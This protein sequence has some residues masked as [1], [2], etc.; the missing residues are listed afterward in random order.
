MTTT[1][2]PKSERIGQIIVDSS[3]PAVVRRA[4]NDLQRYLLAMYGQRVP[5]RNSARRQSRAKATTIVLEVDRALPEQHYVLGPSRKTSKGTDKTFCI[6]GGSP[7]ATAWGAYELAESWGVRFLQHRDLLPDH[8]LPLRFPTQP[9]ERKPVFALRGSRTYNSMYTESHWGVRDCEQLFD[10]F[11]KLRLNMIMFMQRWDDSC[12]DLRW[13]G[14]RKR[15]AESNYGFRIRVREGDV[16]FDQLEAAGDAERGLFGNPDIDFSGDYDAKVSA[17][18]KYLAKVCRM[19]HARGIEV[20]VAVTT[21]LSWPIKKRLVELTD[22]KF[23]K[24]SANGISNGGAMTDNHDLAPQTLIVRWAESISGADQQMAA[25]MSIRNPRFL[26]LMQHVVQSFLDWFEGAD[27]LILTTAEWRPSAADAEFAWN[28][29]D[30]EFR[31]SEIASL[32]QI[33]AECREK[34]EV[35]PDRAEYELKADLCTLWLFHYLI[36][37]CRYRTTSGSPRITP[38][39]LSVELNRFLPRVFSDA[40]HYGSFPG[41]LPRFTVARSDTFEPFSRGPLPCWLL[42]SLEDDNV[43]IVPQWTGRVTETIVRMMRKN[44]MHGFVT[45]QFLRSKMLP[46]MDYLAHAGWDRS[47]TIGQSYEH[48]FG[49]LCGE[50]ALQPLRKAIGILTKNTE[51]MHENFDCVSFLMPRL[52]GKFSP[53]LSKYDYPTSP[54]DPKVYARYQRIG[55][56]Y[57]SAAKWL[58]DAVRRSRPA[59][60]ELLTPMLRQTQFAVQYMRGQIAIRK[61][62]DLRLKFEQAERDH[63]IDAMIVSQDDAIARF[64]E[65]HDCFVAATQRWAECVE[66]R[67]DLAVLACLNHFV[68]RASE[69][70]VQLVELENHWA[71]AP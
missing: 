52:I 46:V 56:L 58:D 66:D 63:D 16:G 37:K 8:P 7:A 34:A 28:E 50:R 29:L 9:M 1:A 18:R 32:D 55:R 5:I 64:R 53:I 21:D 60:R 41:Y 2:Q 61:A 59:G 39:R 62:S 14:A 6:V 49:N 69:A 15:A 20:G 23:R 70:M 26:E 57:G 43:G 51:E 12:F 13:Q 31:I 54:T 44:Y 35:T 10:Q 65:A 24:A 42:V 48:L 25:C 3:E 19:A 38:A 27:Y 4:A 33:V 40:P 17:G 11:V 67:V 36:K 45:R 22:R 47:I 71:T 68:V 30:R